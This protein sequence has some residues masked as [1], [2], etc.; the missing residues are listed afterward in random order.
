MFSVMDLLKTWYR[1][2]FTEPCTV[3]SD[4]SRARHDRHT[5]VVN[6]LFWARRYARKWVRAH[7]FGEAL[8]QRQSKMKE[9]ACS[10]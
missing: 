5:K 2:W 3:S 10:Q 1:K 8:V 4:F 6:G 7:P 9:K